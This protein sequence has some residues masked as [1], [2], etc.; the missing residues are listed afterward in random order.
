M[1][2]DINSLSVY[3]PSQSRHLVAVQPITY[4]ARP[5]A[6]N[7]EEIHSRQRSH[8]ASKIGPQASSSS[9]SGRGILQ[10]TSSSQGTE[11]AYETHI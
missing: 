2:D 4:T 6:A 1:R 10:V 8:Q 5:F 7:I 9:S 3:L 11:E